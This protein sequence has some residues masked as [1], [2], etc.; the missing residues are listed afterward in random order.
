[1]ARQIVV[2]TPDGSSPV[3][4]E[5]GAQDE[6]QLQE[7]LK[8]NPDLLPVEEFGM[9]GPLLVIGRETSL[10]S[11]AVDLVVLARS[12]ELLIIEFKTGPQNTDFRQALAQLL[13]YGSDLWT[14]SY[15]DFESTVPVRYFASDRCRDQAVRGLR[16]LQAA[17]LATWPD[18]SDEELDRI[19]ERISEQLKKGFFHYILVAQ[20]F[21]PSV[22]RAID[23]LN[24]TM[25]EA[26]F[27][28]VEIVRFHG[29]DLSA[30]E[31][32]TVLKPTRRPGTASSPTYT[33]EEQFLGR[34]DDEAYHGALRE[35]FEVCR[36]LDLRFEWGSAGVSIRLPTAD[37]PE[38]LTI[39]WI[40]PPGRAGWMDLTDLTLGF[41]PWS[42][43]RHPSTNSALQQY[44]ASVRAL[45]GVNAVKSK[46]LRKTAY[47]VPPAVL[48]RRQPEVAEI[49]ADLVRRVNEGGE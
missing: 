26:R 23:Y 36:G 31:S 28:A 32:R 17:A 25:S 19:R 15:E 49:L 13:D 30:F 5:T 8:D 47:H 46:N 7:L 44:L 27:Y 41:D 4:E 6:A 38:P 22:E 43:D 14:M 35:L 48:V 20:R 12:G 34:V 16:S 9:T 42:A 11:G 10:P 29:G 3:L 18:L 39:A 37:R 24:A 1:M 21:T 2:H 33:N 40:F 45:E